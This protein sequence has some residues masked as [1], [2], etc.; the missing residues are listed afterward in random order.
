M[1]NK[2][3]I[4]KM[5]GKYDKRVFVGGNYDF[6]ANLREI[7]KYVEAF[8]FQHILALDFDV[9][10][11]AIHDCDLRLLHNCEY[12]IFDITHSAGEVMELERCKDYGTRVM[13]VYQAREKETIPSQLSSMILTAGFRR[14]GYLEFKL[15]KDFVKEFLL[16]GDDG[17]DDLFDLYLKVFGYKFKAIESSSKINKDRTSIQN[18]KFCNL[19]VVNEKLT[20]T[21]E[22]PHFFEIAPMGKIGNGPKFTTDRSD[23]VEWQEDEMKR[24]DTYYEG[25]I[26]FKD[27]FKKG[28][29]S[30]N[31]EFEVDSEG[32]YCMI[33]DEFDEVYPNA[34]FP[35]EYC[36]IVIKSPV[37]ILKL[38]ISFFDDYNV[39]LQPI[40]F[41]G[42]QRQEDAVT[43]PL[44]SFNREENKATLTVKRPR[45]FYEYMIFWEPMSK[46]EYNNP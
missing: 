32:D 23:I 28:D 29:G 12:A 27:G 30:V 1:S 26:V 2:L 44:T 10:E 17:G 31:Y 8:G 14:R 9:P 41:F 45:L 35:Y 22:G 3:D 34:E 33:K 5:P 4:D 38:D 36:S 19:E 46:E 21:L 15:L 13:V 43:G 7:A 11:G 40:A 39:Y 42:K 6:P 16:G 25:N 18:I 37:E 20:K 24:R